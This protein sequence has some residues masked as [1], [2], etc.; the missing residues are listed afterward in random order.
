MKAKERAKSS[1]NYKVTEAYSDR[2]SKSPVSDNYR[3]LNNSPQTIEK[4][5]QASLKNSIN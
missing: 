1:V 4:T 3:I 5:Y 2:C